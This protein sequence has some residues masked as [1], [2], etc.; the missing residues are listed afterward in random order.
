[1]KYSKLTLDHYLKEL[2]SAHAV[3]GGGSAAALVGAN[4]IALI[5]MV[6]RIMLPK[7]VK[8]KQ[9]KWKETLQDLELIA[10]N[11]KKVI[12]EDPEQY[13]KVIAAYAIKK[14]DLKRSLKI[15]KALV[16]SYESMR[17]LAIDLC[18]AKKLLLE[19]KRGAHGAIA[20]DLYVASAFLDAAFVSAYETALINLNYMADE[21]AIKKFSTEMKK[22]QLCYKKIKMK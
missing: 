22:V 18:S 9:K 8:S 10:T 14:S 16:L 2:S 5:C 1:M 11:T 4:G 17:N 15:E 19:I 3:P 6:A 21:S 7:L 12:D 20:N 13:Q